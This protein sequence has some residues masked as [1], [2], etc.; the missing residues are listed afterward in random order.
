MQSAAMRKYQGGT[1][2]LHMKR[3]ARVEPPHLCT[4]ST[5]EAMSSLGGTQY[6]LPSTEVSDSHIAALP[7]TATQAHLQRALSTRSVRIDHISEVVPILILPS[8]I[9]AGPPGL[10]PTLLTYWRTLRQTW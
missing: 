3:E 4:H 7:S 6:Q 8:T 5:R 9:I 10:T 1:P 2:T